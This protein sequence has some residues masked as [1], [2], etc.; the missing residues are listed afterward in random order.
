MQYSS[1]AHIELIQNVDTLRLVVR[2]T[3]VKQR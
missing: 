2:L 3:P 1:S